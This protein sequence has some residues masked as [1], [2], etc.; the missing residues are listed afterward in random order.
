MQLTACLWS[1]LSVG[2]NSSEF[3]AGSHGIMLSVT[4]VITG[5]ANTV[6]VTVTKTIDDPVRVRIQGRVY[7]R[8]LHPDL[9]C[10]PGMMPMS[11]MDCLWHQ[12]LR[13]RQ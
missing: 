12:R 9:T 5:M 13:S 2:F 8:N 4:N 3:T 11:L 1:Q 6:S 7:T 10:L